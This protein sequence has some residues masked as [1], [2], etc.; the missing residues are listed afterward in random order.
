MGGLVK[1]AGAFALAATLC[2]AGVSGVRAGQDQDPPVSQAADDQPPA[3]VV[4]KPAGK[5]EAQKNNVFQL[6]EVEVFGNQAEDKNTTVDRIFSD[7]MLLLGA[8]NVATAANLEPG[9]TL[10]NVGAR[11]EAQIYIRGFGPRQVPVFLDGVPIYDTYF[12][13]PPLAEFTTYGLSEMTISKGFT[14]VLYGPNTMG[15]AINLVTMKPQKEFEV[16]GGS[17]YGSGNSYHGFANFGSNQGKWYFEGGGSYE[18]QDYFN[19]SDSFT[20]TTIHGPGKTLG[21]QGDGARVN[22]YSSDWIAHAKI[23]LTPN[24]T[25]EYALSF[26]KLEEAKGDPPYVGTD[27]NNSARWWQWPYWNFQDVHFNSRTAICGDSYV[28]T[29]AFYDTYDNSIDSFTTSN[30]NVIRFPPGYS[31][32]SSYGDYSYGASMEAGTKLVPYNDIKF[33]FHFKDD[34][35]TAWESIP[36]QSKTRD[37]DRNYSF[38]VEDTVDFTKKL[39]AIVGVSYDWLST[40]EALDIGNGPLLS[41]NTWNPQIGLFYKLT[42]T[43]TIH[44]SA[45]D[46]SRLPTLWERYSYSLKPGLP[47]PLLRPE[48]ATNYEVGYKDLVAGKLQ[49]EATGFYD[50]VKDYVLD[51]ST[52]IPAPGGGVYYQNQNE[53]HVNFFGGE[54]GVNGEILPCLKGGMNYTYLQYVNVQNPLILT[55]LP[56]NK[57]FAYLQYFMPVKGWSMLAS[58]EYDTNRYSDASYAP[59]VA[60]AYT[61]VNFKE[62]YEI[63]PGVTLEGGINNIFDE[64][65]ELEEGYPQAGRTFFVQMRFKY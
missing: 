59:A 16:N 6:G 60:S 5:S 21:Y 13:Y 42:D 63:Y 34:V 8:N 14:S 51:V 55:D 18:N 38:G 24:D 47:N 9:V 50:V 37:E 56:H 26:M 40:I 44:I 65:W 41:F 17:G 52:G 53:G 54:L 4:A 28:K 20:P 25:D 49:V 22:S 46:K 57:V 2:F 61:L 58:V 31:F 43:G 64:N 11:N 32:D 3:S 39:Y 62:I 7:E 48:K 45:E 35:H 10:T 29:I 27:P 36:V 19:L 12:G 1:G 30:Y 15:G 33:A 23:G